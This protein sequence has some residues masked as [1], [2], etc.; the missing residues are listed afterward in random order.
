MPQACTYKQGIKLTHVNYLSYGLAHYAP[1]EH[2]NLFN[3]D[4]SALEQNQKAQQTNVLGLDCLPN[5]QGHLNDILD[6]DSALDGD[7]EINAFL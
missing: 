6:L 5:H 4:R 1:H 7:V 3:Q 2:V